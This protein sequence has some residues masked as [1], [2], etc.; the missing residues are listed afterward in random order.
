MSE[1]SIECFATGF[2]CEKC[3]GPE[4]EYYTPTQCRAR[5][6]LEKERST[7]CNKKLHDKKQDNVPEIVFVAIPW[8]EQTLRL[9]TFRPDHVQVV[10]NR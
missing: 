6:Y 8:Q 3:D 4:S 9:M 2:D 7:T 5:P 10:F 1:G